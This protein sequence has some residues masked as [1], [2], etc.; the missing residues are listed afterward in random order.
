M[1]ASSP[2]ELTESRPYNNVYDTRSVEIKCDDPVAFTAMVEVLL[3]LLL[4]ILSPILS[5]SL[6]RVF[7]YHIND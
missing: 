5:I 2:K 3:L 1:F 7:N 6:F 4:F